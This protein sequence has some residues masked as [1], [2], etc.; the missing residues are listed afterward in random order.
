[1]CGVC[2]CDVCVQTCISPLEYFS[3]VNSFTGFVQ[4][5]VLMWLTFALTVC[6]RSRS[7][8]FCILCASQPISRAGTNLSL[9]DGPSHG[10]LQPSLDFS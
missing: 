8:G 1:M 9:F 4:V 3:P 2:V 5:L 6:F 10:L 7:G